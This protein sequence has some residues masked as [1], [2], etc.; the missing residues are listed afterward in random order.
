MDTIPVIKPLDVLTVLN[1]RASCREFRPDPVDDYFITQVIEAARRAPTSSNLQA[2]SLIVVRDAGLRGR[3]AELAGGQA[4]VA[5]APVFI[6]FCADV[7]RLERACA[8]TD[9]DF[10]ADTLEM[11]LVAALDAGLAG[12]CASLAADSLGLGSVMI[13]GLRN[14]PVEVARLLRF[15]RRVFAVFGL[16]LGWPRST[17]R[18]KPRLPVHAVVHDEV[19]DQDQVDSSLVAYSERHASHSAE[20]AW[21]QRVAHET[22]TPRR[23][24]LRQALSALGFCFD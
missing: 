10:A 8:L 19:Y 5:A 9:V 3:L 4:H 6:A 13:G 1:N 17:G 2:Y 21:L 20:F 16:C 23:C 15:P 12:M 7:W 24:D 22:S 14:H 11:G 18:P